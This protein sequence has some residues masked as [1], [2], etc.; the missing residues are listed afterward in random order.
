[1]YGPNL[2]NNLAMVTLPLIFLYFQVK[3]VPTNVKLGW[4][5]IMFKQFKLNAK[6]SLVQIKDSSNEPRKTHWTSLLW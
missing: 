2:N 1:M 3:A 4:T 5:R 6:P